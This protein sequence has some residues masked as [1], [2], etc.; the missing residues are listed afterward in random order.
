[1]L[2]LRLCKPL[3]SLSPARRCEWPEL[4][5]Q[6]EED[7]VLDGRP[8]IFVSCS[9]EHKKAIARPIESLFGTQGLENHHR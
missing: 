8:A 7:L 2:D 4:W 3:I 1:M 5:H 9:D 6:P